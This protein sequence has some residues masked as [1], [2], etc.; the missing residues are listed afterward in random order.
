MSRIPR[1]EAPF[2][3]AAADSAHRASE[4]AARSPTD[5]TPIRF[6]RAADFDPTPRSEETG[7][8]E[9][10]ASET[11]ASRRFARVESADDNVFEAAYRDVIDGDHH[12]AHKAD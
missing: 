4:S 1:T 10:G 8:S 3:A 5:S 9:T 12:G 7:A 11:G 2:S 6:S